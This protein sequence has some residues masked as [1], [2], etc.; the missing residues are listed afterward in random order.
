M[1]SKAYIEYS[2]K[3]NADVEEEPGP[4]TIKLK[5]NKRVVLKGRSDTQ[6]K[7]TPKGNR[8]TSS[9][10]AKE[11]EELIRALEN[12]KYKTQREEES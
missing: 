4:R 1:T 9:K 8:A 12:R 3:P 10:P 5:E 11:L 2:S 7:D 6:K